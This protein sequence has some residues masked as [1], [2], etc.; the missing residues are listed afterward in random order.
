VSTLFIY[1]DVDI[2]FMPLR[3]FAQS[4]GQKY[5]VNPFPISQVMDEV[6]M[7]GNDPLALDWDTIIQETRDEG[8]RIDTLWKKISS[9]YGFSRPLEEVPARELELIEERAKEYEA[10]DLLKM[11]ETAVERV[12]E[13]ERLA[14]RDYIYEELKR[15]LL[16][17]PEAKSKEGLELLKTTIEAFEKRIKDQ[18]GEFR[19]TLQMTAKSMLE[20]SEMRFRAELGR[21]REEI[22]ESG[23]VPRPGAPLKEARER[24][25]TPP[26]PEEVVPEGYKRE[27][28]IS[29]TETERDPLTGKETEILRFVDIPSD[30]PIF[31]APDGRLFLVKDK[32]LVQV[33]TSDIMKKISPPPP[34]PP[35]GERP[36]IILGAPIYPAIQPRVSI[37]ELI[38]RVDEIKRR[39]PDFVKRLQEE[40]ATYDQIIEEWERRRA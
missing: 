26:L 31:R 28:V 17:T 9:F 5:K 14:L 23:K 4:L 22:K 1:P 27:H 15:V 21:V 2:P 13:G 29:I 7:T 35:L 25:K 33:S 19:E 12:V 6:A 38:D 32:R 11:I 39:D 20:A 18:E 30:L 40:G 36:G 34:K 16:E 24:I 10:E 8:I 37:E 3:E